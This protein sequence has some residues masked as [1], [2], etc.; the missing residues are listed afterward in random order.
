[1]PFIG[2]I[3]LIGDPTFDARE[4]IVR[5]DPKGGKRARGVAWIKGLKQRVPAS[6]FAPYSSMIRDRV[7]S[8]CLRD[9][10]ICRTPRSK[11]D[12]G[13]KSLVLW[14]PNHLRG[15]LSYGAEVTV[16]AGRWLG[17]WFSTSPAPGRAFT[18]WVLDRSSARD[19]AALWPIWEPESLNAWAISP[20][21]MIEMAGGQPGVATECWTWITY[22]G[23]YFTLSARPGS[24]WRLEWEDD[25]DLGMLVRAVF[26]E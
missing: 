21:Q 7:S 17:R 23:C 19:E 8:Y 24:E 9:D 1:M 16:R 15:H 11:W 20:E 10:L 13:A 6:W 14:W 18:R 12:L 22:G 5:W 4:S 26:E 2:G 25:P 3:S